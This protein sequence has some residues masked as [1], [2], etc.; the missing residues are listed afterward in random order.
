LLAQWF[1]CARHVDQTDTLPVQKGDQQETVFEQIEKEQ[2]NASHTD[3]QQ[4]H[5]RTK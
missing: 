5:D 2:R 4:S 1:G 3:G